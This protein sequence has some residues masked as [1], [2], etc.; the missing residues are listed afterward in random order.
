MMSSLQPNPIHSRAEIGILPCSKC[1]KSMR[2]T[3]IEPAAP[4]Y[5]LRIFEC[6]E[7]ETAGRFLIAI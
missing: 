3:R 2:L 6:L 5:D 7:C 4:G 1:G